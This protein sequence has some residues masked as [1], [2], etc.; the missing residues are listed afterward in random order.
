MP[1]NLYFYQAHQVIFAHIKTCSTSS[2]PNGKSIHPHASPRPLCCPLPPS[3]ATSHSSLPHSGSSHK[4]APWA[5]TQSPPPARAPE[6]LSC[7]WPWW[8]T[9]HPWT[10]TPPSSFFPT[11]LLLCQGLVGV[12]RICFRDRPL[13]NYPVGRRSDLEIG[14]GLSW[15]Q[16]RT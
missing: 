10:R 11:F 5:L 8:H 7:S 9:H 12:W 15:L 1:G 3:H 16:R 6:L 14:Q 2:I 13:R 4:A